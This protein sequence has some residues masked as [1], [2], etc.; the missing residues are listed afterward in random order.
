M[1]LNSARKINAVFVIPPG[2]HILDITGPAHLFYEALD[3][4]APLQLWFTHILPADS[5]K[6]SSGLQLSGLI[7]FN[8]LELQAGDLVFMP[9]LEWTLLSGDA[10]LSG[11]RPFQYWLKAQH[12]KGVYVCSVCTG[13][14]LLAE[15]GLLDGHSCTTHWKYFDKFKSKYPLVNLQDNRLFVNDGTIYTSAGVT[16]GIDLALYLIE[17][18]FGA[19]FS[20]QI[21]KEVV[22][23][24][25]RGH[26]D[27]QLSA[28][29]QHRNHLDQRIHMVQDTLSQSL[30]NKWHI[31][32]LA[33]KVSMSDRNLTRLFKKVTGASIGQY[34]DLLRTERAQQLINQ[35]HTMQAAALS[36]G[37]KSAS[38]LRRLLKKDSEL[39]G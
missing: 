11:S 5:V 26:H 15:A 14:F 13:A 39:A 23:Y 30:D 6:S 3:Y 25:R 31:S 21:A 1:S 18:L 28:F 35:G 16:S 29:M 20:A 9:G 17:H 4:G 22:I 8:E 24:L 2:V 33:D 36:C 12:Q 10:F 32:Q 27:P 37:L 34:L 7:N 38:Q 19:S